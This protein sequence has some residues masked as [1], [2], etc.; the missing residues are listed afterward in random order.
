[1]ES[2]TK[3]NYIEW[4]ELIEGLTE[5]ERERLENEDIKGCRTRYRIALLNQSEVYNEYK[6]KGRKS[7]VENFYSMRL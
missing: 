2:V 1:M 5:Q 7:S 6:N 4:I 3:A